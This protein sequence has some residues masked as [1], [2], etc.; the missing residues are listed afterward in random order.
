MKCR[1]RSGTKWSCRRPRACILASLTFLRPGWQATWKI[2]VAF[3][4]LNILLLFY[5]FTADKNTA[6]MQENITADQYSQE[7]MTNPFT[8]SRDGT[9]LCLQGQAPVNNSWLA[10]DFALVDAEDRVVSEFGGESS[11]Y[12]GRDSEG[13]WTEG[14]SS[15][16]S[17]FRVDK[18]GQYR[19]LVYGQGGSDNSGPSRKE[20]LKIRLTGDKTISWYFIIPASCCP[21]WRWLWSLSAGWHSR[22]DG[23]VPLR[24]IATMM[25]VTV[26]IPTTEE[27]E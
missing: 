17:C 14:S 11:F 24:A 1:L 8:V 6:L 15:F 9:I 13:T 4:A 26:E 2:G 5:S 19:L 12:H 27:R 7:Y 3:L 10:A 21:L 20:P 22:L 16:S 18:A 23:G 25:T